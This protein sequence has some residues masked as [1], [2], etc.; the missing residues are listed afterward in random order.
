MSNGTKTV[1][2]T[3]GVAQVSVAASFGQPG[4]Q[5]LTAKDVPALLRQGKSIDEVVALGLL[6]RE[7]I[8]KCALEM[9]QEGKL[10]SERFHR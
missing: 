5:I 10:P 4:G 1:D 3:T 9:V 6:G 7:E 2:P 8:E